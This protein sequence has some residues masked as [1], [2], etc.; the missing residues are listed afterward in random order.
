MTWT[1]QRQQRSNAGY[2]SAVRKADGRSASRSVTIGRIE[3][4]PDPYPLTLRLRSILG[5][6]S[7]SGL[8]EPS[9]EIVASIIRARTDEDARITVAMNLSF[10]EGADREKTVPVVPVIPPPAPVA[11]VGGI[12]PGT[13]EAY[14]TLRAY[15][16][17]IFW[18]ART[19]RVRDPDVK[20][21][22]RGSVR[23]D[24]G[25][26]DL[27]MVHEDLAESRLVELDPWK[28]KNYLNSL[29][30]GP[31][32]KALHQAAYRAILVYAR[33]K[34]HIRT[35]HEF[36]PI[37][38]AASV[39]DPKEPP[40]TMAEI[41][42]LLTTAEDPMRRLM[43]AVAV[44]QGLRPSELVRV[45]WID[46]RLDRRTMFVRGDPERG[47]LGKT[48]AS[49]DE[50]P[51]TPFTIREIERFLKSLGDNKPAGLVFTWMG[52]PI[53]NYKN[54][55]KKAAKR[56]GITRR[57][58]PY[59]LRATMATMAYTL[60]LPRDLTRRIGRWTDDKMLDDVYCRPRATDLAALASAMDLDAEALMLALAAK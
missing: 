56:A 39:Q 30:C 48:A 57:V 28:W 31:R 47:G 44:G 7:A 58:H 10:P 42:A 15:Y 27:I 9:D 12:V 34:G 51:L 1:V 20:V 36:F 46:I 35:I 25:R 3:G 29:D 52:E 55:L 23:G 16:D 60:G 59:L 50:I 21:I 41:A 11:P 13:M 5:T 43:W 54:A 45:E 8:A 38:G 33:R 32:T 26:Y 14:L 37:F 17:S 4:S 40:L 18:P 19:G 24:G 53:A 49:V 6:V 22:A 2:Y